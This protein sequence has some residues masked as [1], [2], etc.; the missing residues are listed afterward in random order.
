MRAT[1]R[2]PSL[3]LAARTCFSAAMSKTTAK[4]T[5]EPSQ[6]EIEQMTRVFERFSRRFKVA[7]AAA[8]ADNALNALDAQTLVYVDQ[9]P[10]CLMGDVARFLNVA[11]TT[12]SSSIDRLVK[13]AFVERRRP[14]DNRRSVALSTTDA[15]RGVVEDHIAGYRSTCLIMLRALDPVERKELIR[16]T[17]KIA[18]NET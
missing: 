12:M 1:L 2:C 5:T 3:E 10:G 8:A 11:M 16:L 6:D 18:D 4:P 14:E 15:G 9:H 17:E 7:E 13:K